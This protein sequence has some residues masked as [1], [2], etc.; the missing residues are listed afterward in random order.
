MPSVF[1]SEI[2]YA[3]GMGNQ[4]TEKVKGYK[5]GRVAQYIDRIID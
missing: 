1:F 4:L 5:V 3:R 2:S